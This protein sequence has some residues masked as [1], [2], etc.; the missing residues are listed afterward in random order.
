M[1][2]PKR[3]PNY[4][5]TTTMQELLDAVCA[6]YGDPV[7]DRKEEDLDHVSLHDV[8]DQFNITVMKARKLLITGR[9]YSTALSRKVQELHAC[10]FR[11]K[12]HRCTDF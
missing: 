10:K 2:M 3:K 11:T 1:P 7:D 5:S 12:S 4:S 6:F 9:L 8:A